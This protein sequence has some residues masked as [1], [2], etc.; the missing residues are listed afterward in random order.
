MSE[1][2]LCSDSEKALFVSPVCFADGGDLIAVMLR[3][4]H[5]E[6]VSEGLCSLKCEKWSDHCIHS[7]TTLLC[8]CT[9]IPLTENDTSVTMEPLDKTNT[10]SSLV[11][12]KGERTV[13]SSN[14][15]GTRSPFL[16]FNSG[17]PLVTESML[18]DHLADIIV[19]LYLKQEHAHIEQT[20]S[21]VCSRVDKRTSR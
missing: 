6:I 13:L 17:S 10:I 12:E 15:A 8:T 2:I 16:G 7:P 19:E 11:P 18:L 3:F 1:P 21:S 20:S 14:K 9:T 4:A 5:L